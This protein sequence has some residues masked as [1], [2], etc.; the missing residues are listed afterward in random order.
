MPQFDYAHEWTDEQLEQLERKMGSAYRQAEREMRQKMEEA[1]K[2]HA[3]Q[4]E[5]REK[6][7]DDSDEAMKAHKLWLEDESRRLTQ[8]GGMVDVLAESATNANIKAAAMA[9]DILPAVFTENANH[10]AFEIDKAIRADTAFTLVDES[11]VRY[12]MGLDEYDPLIHEVIDMGPARPYVQSLRKTDIDVPRDI[13]WNRQKFTA[14]IT[15]GILQGE[16]I[17]NI[18]KRTQDIFGSNYAAATR[19]ARTACTSAECAGRV[20]SYQRA[21]RLGVPLVEEWMATVDS[22]TR[23]SHRQADGQRVEVGESFDVGGYE[24]KYPGDPAGP[25]QEVYN[26]RCTIRGQVKGFEDSGQ[27]GRWMR[28]PK[29]MTYDEWKGLSP[30]YSK[31]RKVKPKGGGKD[32]QPK[33]AQPKAAPIRTKYTMRE[34][35][36]MDRDQLVPIAR[37]V[38]AQQSGK[39]G[40]TEEEALRR[41]DLLI[42]SNPTTYLRKYINKNGG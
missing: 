10:A 32:E 35:S 31:S 8:M 41:F 29:G 5:A 26:C 9:N 17:P 15:Q 21:D 23:S 20:S 19:A 38:A 28:L 1:L 7:L 11:T 13:R 4:R 6:A 16:S 39:M 18:V 40:I 12:L 42:D 33:A 30:N 27:E 36:S 25:P 24:L 14:A 2:E 37:Q 3:S 34:L 22:R